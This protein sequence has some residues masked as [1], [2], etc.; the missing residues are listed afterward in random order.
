MRYFVADN[1]VARGPY[2]P[3]ELRALRISPSTKVWNSTMKEWTPAQWVPEL[4]PIARTNVRNYGS[5]RALP[6]FS[7]GRAVCAL[8]GL[9]PMGILAFVFHGGAQ[10]AYRAGYYSV[11]LRKA[12]LANTFCNIGYIVFCVSI[13]IILVYLLLLFIILIAFNVH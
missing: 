13:I 2:T 5:Q 6:P 1:G 12:R 9:V 11:A 4:A 7:K 8:L 3:K 10:N